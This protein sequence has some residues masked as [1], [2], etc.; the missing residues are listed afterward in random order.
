LKPE[1]ADNFDVA[2]YLMEHNDVD[3]V[4]IRLDDHRLEVSG[5]VDLMGERRDFRIL[6]EK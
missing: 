3:A 2:L 6:W 1:D 5:K 4:S